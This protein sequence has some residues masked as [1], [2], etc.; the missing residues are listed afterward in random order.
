MDI[1]FVI[2]YLNWYSI[3][4]IM[5][6]ISCIITNFWSLREN[7]NRHIHCRYMLYINIFSNMQENSAH[8]ALNDSETKN[9]LT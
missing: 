2:K 6:L 9:N 5:F 1:N 4:L 7:N 8:Y 3:P